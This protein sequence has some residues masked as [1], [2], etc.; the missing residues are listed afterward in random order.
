[1]YAIIASDGRQYKVQEGQELEMDYQDVA[2]G[3]KIKFDQVLAYSDGKSAKLG[4]PVLKGASVT[5]EVIGVTQGEK[6]VVQKFRRRKN[7]RRKT[8][9]RQWFTKVMI[10]KIK[11]E[12]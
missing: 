11:V 10:K 4:R 12:K 1:M 5:A 6:L 8:G 2:S 3:K 9:H 7:S